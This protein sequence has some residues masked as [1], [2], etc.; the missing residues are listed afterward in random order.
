MDRR[1][2]NRKKTGKA[3]TASAGPRFRVINGNAG[4][5]RKAGRLESLEP[6][7]SKRGLV[8]VL[9]IAVILLLA[10]AAVFFI[11]RYYHV[12]NVYVEGNVHYTNEEIIQIVTSE[13]FGDNSIFLYLKY[14]NKSITGIPFIESMDI[15]VMAPDTIK[16]IVY[17]KSIAGYVEY[18]DRY[19]YF[20]KDGIIV[21]ASSTKT[22]GIPEITG[23]EFDQVVMYE[24]LPVENQEVFRKILSMTQILS[25]YGLTAD[26]IYF[27]DAYEMTLYFGDIRARLGSEDNIEEKVARLEQ[28]L[29]SAEG[30]KGV[31][32]MENYTGSGDNVSFEQDG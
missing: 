6:K 22:A 20:D 24:P 28:L 19:M 26:K 32:R 2:A 9:V 11:L 8:A 25:K 27:D 3:G 23:I 12:E 14:R 7:K 17:E 16:I 31:F 1:T 18:L 4:K 5:R 30:K 15:E 10:A 29:P 21:E 13:R